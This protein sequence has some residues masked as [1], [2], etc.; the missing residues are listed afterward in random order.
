[1]KGLLFA[2]VISPVFALVHVDHQPKSVAAGRDSIPK[3]LYTFMEG[4]VK[5][6]VIKPCFNGAYYRK[7]V[8][9]KD[10]WLGIS[11]TVVLPKI[12]LDSSRRN[13]RMPGQFLDNPSVYMGGN[14]NEQETDVGLT[15]AVVKSENGV[16]S[17]ERKAFRPFFRRAGYP[18]TGQKDIWQNAPA[19]KAYYWY[20]GEEVHMSLRVVSDGK[21]KFMVE[22]A[23]KRFEAEFESD[24]YR[25]DGVGEFKRV[26]AI[27]QVRNEGKAAQPTKARVENSVWKA[28]NLFR[29][30]KGKVITVPMHRDRFTDMRCPDMKH[31]NIKASKGQQKVGGESISIYGNVS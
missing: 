22:G 14:M 21:L 30:Y 20:P 2:L 3:G 23:G 29:M 26:N 24:G 7:A 31:F 5:P 11:G 1:M 10:V 16:V 28:T 4:E 12:S 18:K 13:D 25:M 6:D 8:S 17:K 15:W 9:S 19:E 27:D